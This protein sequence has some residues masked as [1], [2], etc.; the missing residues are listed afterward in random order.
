MGRRPHRRET[1]PSP[2]TYQAAG[3]VGEAARDEQRNEKCR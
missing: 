1:S 2:F 3:R